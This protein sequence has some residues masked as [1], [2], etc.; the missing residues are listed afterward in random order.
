MGLIIDESDLRVI[1]IT[2]MHGLGNSYI[3]INQFEHQLP[4]AVLPE[5]ARKLSDVHTGIGSDGMILIGPSDKADFRMRIFNIDGSEGKNCGNGLRC[6]AKYAIERGLTEQTAFMIETLSG[7]VDVQAHLQERSSSKLSDTSERVKVDSVTVN[8]G[9]PR[10]YKRDLPMVGEQDSMT[11]NEE[12]VVGGETNRLTA[13][14]MGN[15]H[16]VFFVADVH[17]VDLEQ[18]GPKIEHDSLFPERINVEFVHAVNRRELDF[19]VWERGSGITQA[20]G[21][22]A[23]AAVVAGVL[24][25]VI[26]RDVPV[27]VHLPGG[28]LEI[29]WAQGNSNVYMKGPA[30]FVLDGEFRL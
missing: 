29:V 12:V 27:T 15:P 6:V 20:C 8:M 1:H 18:I 21:T 13:V 5:L 10:L 24:N 7:V 23:C 25:G 17:T 26:E 2:K 16:A 14:S 19:R 28:D 4:E 30:E 11:V 3:Y 22:G 9:N